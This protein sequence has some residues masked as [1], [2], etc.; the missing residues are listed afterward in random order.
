MKVETGRWLAQVAEDLGTMDY[1]GVRG[2]G[3]GGGAVGPGPDLMRDLAAFR[4]RL[5]HILVSVDVVVL[6]GS[7]ARGTAGPHS[8]VDPLIVSPAFRG[9]TH[10]QRAVATRKA[11]GLRRPADFLCFTPEEFER[12]RG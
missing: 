5:Q 10:V 8:D 7:Q 6:F 4:R 1:L 3:Q 12:L 2:A 9:R 11:W